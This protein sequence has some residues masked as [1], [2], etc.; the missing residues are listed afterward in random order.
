VSLF[1]QPQ[2][3]AGLKSNLV[4]QPFFVRS[5]SCSSAKLEVLNQA[6]ASGKIGFGLL[7]ANGFSR[8]K[9]EPVEFF[10]LIGQWRT[11]HRDS[12]VL[13]DI[14]W[15]IIF[16]GGGGLFSLSLIEAPTL[17]RRH[18]TIKRYLN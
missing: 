11:F 5:Q 15:G 16:T 2:W 1:R 10:V 9:L 18:R 7:A 17:K 12:C 13:S 4:D 14:L 6:Y 8:K 3:S